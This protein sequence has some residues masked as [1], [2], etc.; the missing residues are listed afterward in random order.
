LEVIF[1]PGEG[2]DHTFEEAHIGLFLKNA[3]AALPTST[4]ARSSIL[5]MAKENYR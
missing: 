5:E 2:W 4:V 3:D 1:P